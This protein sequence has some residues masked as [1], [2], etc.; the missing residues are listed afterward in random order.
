MAVYRAWCNDAAASREGKSTSGDS[1]QL[2]ISSNKEIRE[3]CL[4]LSTQFTCSCDESA[5]V[6]IRALFAF[7]ARHEV[8]GAGDEC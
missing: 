2:P 5:L 7:L 4:G 1:I 6:C 8:Y 3:Q